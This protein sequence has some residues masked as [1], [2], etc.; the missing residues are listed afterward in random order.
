MDTSIIKFDYSKSK[1]FLIGLFSDT[2][3]DE[4]NFNKSLFN[5]HIESVC[6]NNGRIF[7]NGDMGNFITKNDRKRYVH[8]RDKTKRDSQILEQ[9]DYIVTILK[10]YVDYIFYMGIGNHEV[11]VIKYNTVNP[12]FMIA[13][14][15]NVF[16][17]K[18][19]PR[20]HLG[21][22]QGFINCFFHY[23]DK[24]AISRYIIY[25]HHGL[26]GLSPVT[27]GMIDF[28]RI[29]LGFDADCY[30]IGHKH[31]QFV[32]ESNHRF[33]T[34][35]VGTVEKK[36]ITNI[37]TAGYEIGH[38]I[39]VNTESFGEYDIKKDDYDLS[40]V[41]ENFYT[42]YGNGFVKLELEVTNHKVLSSATG[43]KE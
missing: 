42:P 30:W 18:N 2:H 24:R 17:N 37:I 43:V 4:G 41:E 31:N 21:D 1:K 14:D 33:S 25:R 20:I 9:I 27:K 32:D 12:L 13:K 5:D 38:K 23:G 11:S 34:N 29:N 19:L 36:K 6:N 3:I 8:S 15:L 26:G 22:Y 28:S 16:R 39:K 7:F 35:A 10:P 40:Y